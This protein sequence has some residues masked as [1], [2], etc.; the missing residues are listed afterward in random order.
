MEHLQQKNFTGIR[1][2]RP[3]GERNDAG[4]QSNSSVFKRNCYPRSKG[5]CFCLDDSGDTRYYE[6]EESSNCRVSPAQ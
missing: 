1:E 4:S 3:I 2:G 6:K 5:R